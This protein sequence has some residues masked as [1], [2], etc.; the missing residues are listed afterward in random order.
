M[1]PPLFIIILLVIL[2]AV[3]YF[4]FLRGEAIPPFGLGELPGITLPPTRATSTLPQ[5][6]FLSIGTRE[7]T[8]TVKNF[9]KNAV[10]INTERDVLVTRTP[11]YD[12]VYF[13]SDGGFSISILATPFEAVRAKAEQAFLER[14][15]VGREDACRLAV[16]IGVP[17]WV[18]ENLAGRNYR[19]SFC[20]TG[21]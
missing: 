14:L 15:G 1:R 20:G 10:D 21:I 17:R 7:G 5:G 12:I 2:G 19:L 13:A 18:D 3:V 9:Y 8:V 11:E 16:Y 4:V 6:D